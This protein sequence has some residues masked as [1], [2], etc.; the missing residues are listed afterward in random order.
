MQDGFPLIVDVKRGSTEDGPGIRT[1]VFF[2]GCPLTCLWCHNPETI[3]PRAEIGFYLKR[4]IGCG[5]CAAA[6]PESAITLD[7]PER[8]DRRRC[9]RCG[10]CV[11]ACPSRALRKI[12]DCY[13]VQALFDL[14]MRDR[15]FYEVSGGGVTLSGG[16][17]ALWPVYAGNLLRK[18]KYEKVHTTL[19]TCGYFD[20][21]AVVEN[22][23][24]WLDLVLFDFKIMDGAEHER[25][26]GKRNERILENFARLLEYGVEIKPRVPLIPG[27]T[28]SRENVDA[29]SKFLRGYGLPDCELLPYNPLGMSKWKVLGRERPAKAVAGEDGNSIERLHVE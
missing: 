25:C 15:V 3:N 20:Y 1:T 16:E 18:L 26:T 10:S 5:E 24:P 23:L 28:D 29:T 22:M 4:C 9:N 12:G 11:G 13:D 21:A 7:S 17:P 2:K 27:Y 14:V 8:I 6:C 19:E